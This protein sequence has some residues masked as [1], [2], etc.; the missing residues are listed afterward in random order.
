MNDER[1]DSAEPLFAGPDERAGYHE[2]PP[3]RRETGRATDVSGGGFWKAL[4]L[5]LALLVVGLAWFTWHQSLM[6]REMRDRFAELQ[7][8]LESTGATLNESGATLASQ[9]KALDTALDANRAEIKKLWG[10]TNDRNR[11]AI[12]QQGKALAS[13]QAEVKQATQALARS[14][15]DAEAAQAAVAAMKSQL[16][17]LA[18]SVDSVKRERLAGNAG[19]D[20]LR[21]Q[22]QA[23]RSAVSKLD[24]QVRGLRDSMAKNAAENRQALT[25]IDTFRRET[26][27][28]LRAM[29]EQLATP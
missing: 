11:P 7:S 15:R 4:T 27:L 2:V 12:E 5:S 18:A 19:L 17:A 10:V 26:N 8:R 20:E 13:L 29:R 21:T 16:E 23:S 9:L 6:Q 28:Q 22:V 14:S 25:A 24:E 3:P 1:F